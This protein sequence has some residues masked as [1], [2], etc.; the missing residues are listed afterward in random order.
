MKN[1]KYKNIEKK[2]KNLK[3]KK[4]KKNIN[5]KKIKNKNIFLRYN[6]K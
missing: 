6:I 5:N 1:K 4:I 3:N 2:I